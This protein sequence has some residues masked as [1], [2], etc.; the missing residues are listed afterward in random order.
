MK[1]YMF[2]IGVYYAV[3]GLDHI[4]NYTNAKGT[5]VYIMLIYK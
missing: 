3:P 1:P 4:L 5:M 2:C